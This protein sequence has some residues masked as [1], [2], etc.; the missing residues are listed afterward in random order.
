MQPKVLGIIPARG[1]SKRLPRK[2]IRIVAGLPMIAHTIKAAQQ[3]TRLTDFLVSSEDREILDIAG[4]YGAP[5]PF[6][7]PVRLADDTV[8]NI[9]VVIHALE[10]MEQVKG[11][12][13]DLLV[14]LQPTTPIRDPQH[15]DDAVRQGSDG[16]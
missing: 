13:Y 11:V 2:N 15:I 3:A 9:D 4:Q 10:M 1:G 7:R 12:V 6:E 14:L 5:V 8:R 16:E